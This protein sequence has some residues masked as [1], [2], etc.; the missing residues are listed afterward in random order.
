[1]ARPHECRALRPGGRG[2]SSSAE[3]ETNGKTLPGGPPGPNIGG[4]VPAFS[5]FKTVSIISRSP[6]ASAG[7]RRR[8]Q[9]RVALLLLETLKSQDLPGEI[10]DDENVTITL[11]RRLGLSDVIEAQIRRYRNEARRRRSVPEAEVLDLMRLVLRR[12]DADEV[13][14][15]VGELLHGPVRKPGLRRF[16][17]RG[18]A[19]SRARRRTR[20]LLARHFGGSVVRTP[21]K[22]FI[23]EADPGLLADADAPGEACAL[24]TGFANQVLSMYLPDAPP[25]LHPECRRGGGDVCRWRLAEDT[26]DG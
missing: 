10:L 15:R 3:P 4:P 14:F 26:A 11:P 5:L 20:K 13:F 25:V 8:I 19:L 17:P 12:P 1:M 2:H 7:S 18:V 22:G 16:L 6:H 21:G 9:A 23:L 24:I